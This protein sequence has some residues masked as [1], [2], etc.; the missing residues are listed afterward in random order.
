VIA[1][2]HYSP[3]MLSGDATTSVLVPYLLSIWDKTQR[4]QIASAPRALG[5]ERRAENIRNFDYELIQF[6]NVL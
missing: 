6:P 4:H 5:C 1:G 2:F 3:V